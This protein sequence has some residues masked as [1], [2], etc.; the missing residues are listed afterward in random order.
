[1][2][3]YII[4]YLIIGLVITLFY[5]LLGLGQEAER[6]GN[7]LVLVIPMFVSLWP[8]FLLATIGGMIKGR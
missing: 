4:V 3:E 6:D 5:L 8:V 2:M 7:S 1:M